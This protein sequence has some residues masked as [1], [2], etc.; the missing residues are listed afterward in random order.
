MS[1]HS[2]FQSIGSVVNAPVNLPQ[3]N[4]SNI[5]VGGSQ[6]VGGVN[7]GGANQPGDGV[8]EAP[9]NAPVD[10]K[11]EATKALMRQLDILLIRAAANSTKS[12]DARAVK[13]N[14]Q[15]LDLPDDTRAKIDKLADD[16]E[17]QFKAIN[18][19]TGRQIGESLA[20]EGGKIVWRQ[21]NAAADAIRRAIDSQLKLS[22][23]LRRLA[24]ALPCCE[25]ANSLE[26]AVFQCD[27]RAS[28]IENLACE[29][30]DIAE[31]GENASAEV[32]ARLEATLD[33][34]LP[35]KALEMHGNEDAI[36]A[37][38]A[39]VEP[40]AKRLDDISK[41]PGSSLSKN[42]VSAVKREIDTMANALDFV[43]K[44]GCANG[45][46]ADRSLFGAARNVL[47]E[48]KSKIANARS[49][50]SAASLVNFA[51]HVFVV[52]QLQ[53]LAPAFRPFLKVVA[54]ELAEAVELREKLCNAA[55][56]YAKKPDKQNLQRM[57]QCAD[58]A[59]QVDEKNLCKS[60]KGLF[61]FTFD[62]SIAD[63]KEKRLRLDAQ[64]V[65]QKFTELLNDTTEETR[66][67]CSGSLLQDFVSLMLNYRNESLDAF[68]NG[69]KDGP[70]DLL[71][72]A[73]V[74]PNA[75]SS[76]V[77]H[78]ELLAN[79]AKSLKEDKF[80]TGGTVLAAFEGEIRFTTIVEARMRGIADDEVDPKLDDINIES[81]EVLGK[82][83]VNTVY[84]VTCKDGS[85]Y[86]FKPESEGRLAIEKLCFT[87]GLEKTQMIAGLNMAT[88]KTAEALGL[89]DIMTKTTV[90]AHK[91]SFGIF[92]EKAPGMTTVSWRKSEDSNAYGE[93]QLSPKQIKEL[94]DDKYAKVV[95]GLLRQ[96]NRMEWFDIITGQGDRHDSNYLL[97]VNADDFSVSLKAIDNDACFPAYRT[98]IGKYT[99]DSGTALKFKKNLENIFKKLYPTP[100]FPIRQAI[101]SAHDIYFNGEGDGFTRNDDDSVTIDIS[102][103]KSP[104]A[105]VALRDTL[106]IQTAVLPDRI[107]EE[108][109]NHLM[110]LGRNGTARKNYIADLKAHLSGPAVDAAVKR[111]DDAVAHAKKLAEHGKVVSKADWSTHETQRKIVGIIDRKSKN[112]RKK[113][114]PLVDPG[115]DPF[116]DKKG[117]SVVASDYTFLSNGFFRRDILRAIAKDGWFDEYG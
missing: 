57:R 5:N 108:L 51:E 74:P 95:G 96:A 52:P 18:A 23:V 107:D 112:V 36:K 53:I 20:S 38:K 78:L 75:M 15:K 41:N 82:G 65:T 97:A 62:I 8:H 56:E 28:E 39:Q 84:E 12:V 72:I 26:E 83:N 4:N 27:R 37:M 64:A 94:S 2:N 66:T 76:Q 10:A 42:E 59:A 35:R 60:L 73:F 16:A 106:G 50:I 87:K 113:E 61:E 104:M 98:G 32:K 86:V 117:K 43:A 111:L 63:G 48:V 77:A 47:A 9:Q 21:G 30:A 67:A 101:N 69:R 17:A 89:G 11:V 55:K 99:L 110:E 14:L 44:S 79:N 116:F 22:G 3:A 105:I 71:D 49:E 19:F 33:K 1:G 54:P 103:V 114:L 81:S 45:V 102:K 6:S 31:K 7:A 34:M 90:G 91:G 24:N 93:G 68:K 25:I 40:L 13:E 88:Q 100:V 80:Q 109:Y 115:L 46:F 85:K 58:A 29:F 70:V 92:M